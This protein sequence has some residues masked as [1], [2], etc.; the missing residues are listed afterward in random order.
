M[1]E[2]SNKD[3][4][5]YIERIR[6]IGELSS[7]LIDDM[8]SPDDYIDTLSGNFREIGGL[9]MDNRK[10]IADK[11]DPILDS[12]EPLTEETIEQI[13]ELIAELVDANAASVT[14]ANYAARLSE[15]LMQHSNEKKDIQ[16]YLKCIDLLI[17]AYHI[18]YI[19]ATP[20]ISAAWIC[21][22]IRKKLID[23]HKILMRFIDKSC[24]KQL[25]MESRYIVMVN[26]RFCLANLLTASLPV[27][28]EIRQYC[29]E[30]LMKCLSYASDPFYTEALPDY[31]WRGHVYRVYE[32]FLLVID[33]EN[34]AG[35]TDSE[36]RKIAERAEE[37]KN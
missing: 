30:G 37:V 7:P 5:A 24:F 20:I 1:H 16:K 33:I 12:D 4:E 6:K 31:N 15:R 13:E 9:A 18:Q 27:Q 36:L 14:D 2:L 10:M 22:E 8:R 29:Y 3:F 11:L 34:Y 32:Y 35:Y 26:A 23:I 19:Y 17:T 25:D 21:D 28:Y